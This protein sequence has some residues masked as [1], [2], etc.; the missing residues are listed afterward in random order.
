MLV[1]KQLEKAADIAEKVRALRCTKDGF[2]LTLF[3]SLRRLRQKIVD[4]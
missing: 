3:A 4:S 1:L 2:K